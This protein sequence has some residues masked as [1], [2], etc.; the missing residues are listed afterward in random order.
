M[1]LPFVEQTA[2][3]KKIDFSYR[4]DNNNG[5][6]VNNT[7]A[8][9]KIDVYL[10]PSDPSQTPYTGNWGGTSYGLSAGPGSEWALDNYSPGA[11]T[12]RW[13][14]GMRDIIDG[15]SN[16][17]FASELQMGMNRGQWDPAAQNRDPSYRVVVGSRLE[18]PSAS[19][20]G[21]DNERRTWR[22]TPGHITMINNYYQTCLGIYDSGGGWNNSSDEQGRFWAAGRVFWGPYHTTLIGPN[23]GPSCDVDSS[24]TDIDLKEPS[25]HHSGGVQV[26][27]GDGS[28]RFVSNS[29]DQT[30][31][32]SAGSINGRESFTW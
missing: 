32:I 27:L 31:W 1:I 10:C 6:T 2:A 18:R 14:K 9:T 15:A 12:F 21:N 24:V 28:V 5:G 17:I 30:V 19:A 16:T 29:I 20:G 8:R 23:A 11:F 22:A 13:N 26:L 3:Y 7:M 4:W 25:S